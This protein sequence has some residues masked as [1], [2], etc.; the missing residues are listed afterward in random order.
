[1]VKATFRFGLVGDVDEAVCE[2]KSDVVNLNG[3]R[4]TTLT[5]P[6]MGPCTKAELC[7]TCGMNS[8]TCLGHFGYISLVDCVI[9][10]HFR[11]LLET[12]CRNVCYV[13]RS[14][15]LKSRALKCVCKQPA[16]L[17]FEDTRVR[18]ANHV[19][20]FREFRAWLESI[21]TST[22]VA[23]GTNERL[24]KCV[25]TKMYVL[26][27]TARP[28]SYDAKRGWCPDP[29]TTAYAEVL[30]ANYALAHG[31]RKTN[32]VLHAA[33]CKSINEL[34]L[35]QQ[36]QGT[37]YPM[38]K[39]K[40][41][42]SKLDK[43]D[44]LIR[45]NL[46]GSRSDQSGRAVIDPGPFLRSDNLGVPADMAE[47]LTRPVH[48]T[49]WNLAQCREW[50]RNNR[51]ARIQKP[52]HSFECMYATNGMQSKRLAVG[53]VVHR[54]LMD[55]DDVV[56]NRQPSLHRGSMMHY[57]TIILPEGIRT[58]WIPYPTVKPFNGDFDG[59]EMCVYVPQS[60]EA[61]A[62]CREIM[63]IS[64]NVLSSQIGGTFLGCIMDTLVGAYIM[65]Q[66]GLLFNRDQFHRVLA[67]HASPNED[68]CSDG[69][70]EWTPW[71][72]EPTPA[73]WV[74]GRGTFYTGHQVF[75]TLLPRGM[76]W[77]DHE[78][79][80]VRDG[81]LLVGRVGKKQIGISSFSMNEH[82]AKKYTQPDAVTFMT[83]LDRA[84]LNYMK[85]RGFSL[86]ATDMI[87]S[88]E[89][90]MGALV[91]ETSTVFAECDDEDKIAGR[92]NKAREECVERLVRKL[93]PQNPLVVMVDSGSKGQKA[94]VGQIC[95][96][97]GQQTVD[98]P[99]MQKYRGRV[100]TAFDSTESPSHRGF[101][102]GN[103][104]KGLSP[105]DMQLHA[106][107]ARRGV[108]E[109]GMQT[110][111]TGYQN[112]K[113]QKTLES[114]CVHYDGTVRNSDGDIVQ[115][116][117]GMHGYSVESYQKMIPFRIP[118]VTYDPLRVRIDR[119]EMVIGNFR[120]RDFGPCVHTSV[121]LTEERKY[122]MLSSLTVNG[123]EIP[124]LV[125]LD[126]CPDH[127]AEAIE[128]VRRELEKAKCEPGTPV[129][130]WAAQ[131]IG[132]RQSQES[133]NSFHNAGDVR[134]GLTG[135]PRFKELAEK[136]KDDE[137]PMATLYPASPSRFIREH[138]R[139]TL[140][141]LIREPPTR[142]QGTEDWETIWFE[143]FERHTNVPNDKWE[144]TF[145]DDKLKSR[146]VR[147][148][149]IMEAMRENGWACCPTHENETERWMMPPR[150][151]VYA[152]SISTSLKVCGPNV[153]TL[154][155]VSMYLG[156]DCVD[157]CGTTTKDIEKAILQSFTLE[158]DH[159]RT[160]TTSV[161][162]TRSIWGIRAARECLM[163][164][165]RMN[166]GGGTVS[167]IHLSVLADM[168]MRWGEFRGIN[169]YGV[170]GK[171][172]S[173]M[174]KMAYE[175]ARHHVVEAAMRGV[176]DRATQPSARMVAGERITVGTGFTFEL[177]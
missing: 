11:G 123:P 142:V 50:V 120:Q 86:D 129:G 3:P 153:N 26:P 143:C 52:T 88:D 112:R 61:M 34:L 118:V 2:V 60:L 32:D 126:V 149:D 31:N 175:K 6:R 110:A 148:S 136:G 27:C 17:L 7:A 36:K 145:S 165:L 167:D 98:K 141:D 93:S 55:G 151:R 138:Q 59:D 92:L 161:E 113:L 95:A 109:S 172:D 100:C 43:K 13:C 81:E 84:M 96:C 24:E 106:R 89:S 72:H 102:Y 173:A 134:K 49:T 41:L 103:F 40:G 4:E 101:V 94:N 28:F 38:T 105:S 54:K 130:C 107:S 77:G 8:R 51:V 108:V 21:P 166:L 12:M 164:E 116:V 18:V 23:I 46:M 90:T 135:Y 20:T 159:T 99:L 63:S 87:V 45:T 119:C 65:T 19:L 176:H 146:C 76:T 133:L 114:V 48:V 163:A 162:V 44:G 25:W 124:W 82:I 10:K 9:P 111:H 22:Y 58:L 177:I 152:P 80:Y 75:S 121:R 69:T 83:K 157:V 15:S 47:K 128:Y 74:R 140:K 62:E 16:K 37:S 68:V 155:N 169:V 79:T 158:L 160:T 132:E 33:L 5:D 156:T 42:L 71:Y 117:Y 147:L 53:D 30:R 67:S 35:N 57:R 104:Y 73:I 137:R 122:E 174:M 125:S 78:S 170:V 115:F 171:S 14:Y 66:P 127:F 64:R 154:G 131:S 139:T 91:Q 1:M 39:E 168:L 150:I 29:V 97:L 70:C 144:F 56:L 85:W